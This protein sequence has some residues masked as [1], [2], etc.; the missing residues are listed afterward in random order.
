MNTPHSLLIGGTRGIGRAL[1]GVLSDEGHAVSVI[2]QHAPAESDRRL[3]NVR[4][5]IVDLLERQRLDAA[6]A[7]IVAQTGKINNLIFLQRYRGEG[8]AWAG[9][10]KTSVTATKE[11]I[12]RL[13]GEFDSSKD[14]SIVLVSSII[15]EFV[16]HNQPLSYHVA[17]A[18]FNQMIRYYAVFLGP[19][20]IRVNG[21]SPATILKDE[22][23][24][25]YVDDAKLH[26]LYKKIIPLR[27][28]GAAAEVAQ[29]VSFLC[30]PKAS[31]VTG[32]NVVVDGG[33]TLQ[34]QESLVR[35][36]LGLYD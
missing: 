30:S 9:E 20:G 1:A 22:S 31:F 4:H 18:A 24:D 21:V 8:D 29:V 26:D 36:L 35:D 6:F 33:L 19:K 14:R 16:V 27:R 2:G 7:E 23:R 13:V 25:V 5:W 10:L 17:K 15:A 12:E 11:I 34:F 28:L 3:P 32:Q